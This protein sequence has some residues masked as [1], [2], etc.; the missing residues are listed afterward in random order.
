MAKWFPKPSTCGGC[1]WEFESNG[2][3]AG[4]GNLS[5]HLW[6]IAESA[7]KNEAEQGKPLVGHTGRDLNNALAMA[8]TTRADVYCDNVIRCMPPPG[9]KRAQ[10]I[11]KD[12]VNFCTRVHIAPLLQQHKPNTILALGE[13]SLNFL[14]GRRG[15]TRQRSSVLESAYAFKVV[16]TIHF[17]ALSHDSQRYS[18]L[19]PFIEYDISRAVKESKTPVLTRPLE[20]FNVKP[21]Y[22]DWVLFR[23]EI[24]ASGQVTIDIETSGGTWYNTAVLCIGFLISVG[25]RRKG[26]SLPLLD[27]FGEDYWS[28]PAEFGE[29]LADVHD[30]LGD[31]HVGKVFQ[32]ENYEHLVLES[33]G[34]RIRGPKNDTMLKHHVIACDKGIPHSLQFITSVYTDLPYYKDES[35]GEENFALLDPI[36]LRTYN[37]RD[38][39][40]TSLANDEMEPELDELGVRHVYDFD[41]QLI[42]AIRAMQ[43]R[44]IIV[45]KVARR[46]YERHV[47]GQLAELTADLRQ[48]VGPSFNPNSDKQL[49]QYLFEE[50]GL[51]PVGFTKGR[52]PTV[53]IDSLLQIQA[54]QPSGNGLNLFLDQLMLYNQYTK[55]L[56]TYLPDFHTDHEGAVH[57]NFNLHVTPHGRLSS[58]NPNLLNIPR[59]SY[60]GGRIKSLFIARPGHMFISRDYSQIEL[61]IY[62]YAA[63]DL[64]LIKE[65]E[66]NGDPHTR[67]AADLFGV[68]PAAVLPDQRDIAKTFHYGGILYGG[69]AAAIRAQA[70]RQLLRA[71]RT[72]QVPEQSVIERAQGRWYSAHPAAAMFNASIEDIAKKTRTATTLI[73]G[74]KRTFFGA[75]SEAMRAARSTVISGTAAD[76][77]NQAWLT[78]YREMEGGRAG[79]VLQVHDELLF[80]VPA[81]EEGKWL[82]RTREVMEAPVKIGQYTVKPRTSC[83]VG[84]IWGKLTTVSE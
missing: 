41:M 73:L 37:L 8:G 36:Q 21:T 72:V 2:Y 25:Q 69:G 68:D 47:D 1:P 7:G 81:V 32:N 63:N 40:A 50:L 13:Y 30:I 61:W 76:I 12:V 4:D 77:I 48:I 52:K 78:L 5:S 17:A 79:V 67:T 57:A 42:D 84:T 59:N 44:G 71:R 26:L 20:D 27:K 16:P 10:K 39:L 31:V 55:T 9:L 64:P 29:I 54:E 6:V 3:A 33:H 18:I 80:E 51:A 65:F 15:I 56:S 43:R 58:S 60:D 23:D 82:R 62:A 38:C 34:F 66:S 14:T 28:S 46:D 49:R 74:R 19:R 45:D 75:L 83:K 11:P 24:R 53:D 22:Q 35:K 70:S